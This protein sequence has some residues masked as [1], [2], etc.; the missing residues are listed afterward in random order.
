MKNLNLY[1]QNHLQDGKMLTR[2]AAP[3]AET[4]LKDS[5]ALAP[6]PARAKAQAHWVQEVGGRCRDMVF[7]HSLQVRM[8]LICIFTLKGHIMWLHSQ[9]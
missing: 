1:Q 5:R 7:S 9:P 3:D 4:V 6:L 8:G 2:W